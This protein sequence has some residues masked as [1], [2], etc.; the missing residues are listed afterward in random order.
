[1]MNEKRAGTPREVSQ[2]YGIPEGSL[3]NLRWQR[4]GP[5]FYRRGRGVVYFFADIEKWLR[6]APVLTA[7][8]V[9]EGR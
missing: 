7:D 3:A 2:I 8:S 4:K 5:R 6:S 9:A 1:M